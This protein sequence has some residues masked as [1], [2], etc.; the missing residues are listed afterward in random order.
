MPPRRS[1]LA[2]AAL[3]AAALCSCSRDDVARPLVL[4]S[5]PIPFDRHD[6][7]VVTAGKLRFRGGVQ[8]VSSDADF[9]GVSSLLVSADGARFVAVTDEGHWL[10]GNFEYAG[11]NLTAVRGDTIAPILDPDGRSMKGKAG[12]AE[13]LASTADDL[14]SGDF[15]VSFEGPHRIWRY[16]FGRDGVVARPVD[17]P[18][19]A[20]ARNAP[21]NGGIE[22]LLLLDRGVLLAFSE[23]QRDAAGDYRAWELPFAEGRGADGTLGRADSL[24]PL[25]PDA[26][27]Y[28]REFAVRPVPPFVVTDARRLPGGDVLLLERS[29]DPKAGVGARLRRIAVATLAAAR[30]GRSGAPLDGE[31]VAELGAA[32]HIDNLEALAVRRGE[33]GETLVYLASDDNFNR[34]LQRTL[35]LMFELSR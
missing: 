4:T 28:E 9:G 30:R 3:A 15:F 24:S 29:F 13:G 2:A 6:S 7:T 16:A 19:P 17:F 27:G 22:A 18:L 26:V 25:P 23:R 31:V 35:V 21:L 11:G 8:L 32:H 5:S 20:A 14:P 34:P 10:T 12:D 1:L 33:A